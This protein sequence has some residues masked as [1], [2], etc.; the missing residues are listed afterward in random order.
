[1]KS[2]PVCNRTYT[3]ET[4]RFCLE[5]GTPLVSQEQTTAPTVMMPAQPPPTVAYDPGRV[6][7]QGPPS[8]TLDAQPKPKRRVWPWVVAALVLLLIFGVGSI[9]AIV[10]MVSVTSNEN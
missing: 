5:D 2:C 3:D 7:N 9:V 8:W 4:L 6:T 10:W 1:M